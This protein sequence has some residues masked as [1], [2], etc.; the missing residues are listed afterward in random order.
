[1][2]IAFFD[3]DRTL[4]SINSGSRWISWELRRGRLSPWQVARAAYYLGLYR[5]GRG[6]LEDALVEAISTLKGTSAAD[7]RRRVEEFYELH[8][9]AAYRPGGLKALA[10]H[11]EQG[12]VTALL[13]ST[14]VYLAEAVG[15]ELSLDAVICNRFEVDGSGEHTG[16]SQGGLCYG[17]G[18]LHHA[19]A[20]AQSRGVPLDE[21]VFYTDSISDLPVLERVGR[22][23][24]VNPDRPLRKVAVRK[25]WEVVDWGRPASGG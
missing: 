15:R 20:F 5:L 1:M 14:S 2:G 18:K 8:V 22:P 19:Q 9:R 21:C 16:R 7:T 10:G 23:V 3:L 24:V 25:R 6:R 17:S 12:D 13:S 11:K 4:L